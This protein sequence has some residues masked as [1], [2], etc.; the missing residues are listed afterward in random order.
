MSKPKG[1]CQRR[2]IYF[3]EKSFQARFIIK[4]C[5]IVACGG[6]LTVA[7][8]YLFAKQSTTVS[9]VNSRAVVKSTADFLLPI[10]LQTTLIVMVLVSFATIAVTLF[11]SHKMSGPLYRFKEVMDA[12]GEGDYLSDF[13][14]RKL[15]QLQDFANAFNEMIRKMRIQINA[16]KDDSS[17]LHKKLDNISDADVVSQKKENLKELKGLSDKLY[18]TVSRLKT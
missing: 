9:I 4:F 14:I 3:I 17:A 10:L 15:D 12:L 8:I 13:K 18:K 1:V 5:L 7:M 2:R 16:L 6:L 11:V